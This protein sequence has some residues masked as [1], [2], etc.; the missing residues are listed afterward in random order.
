MQ[1]Y[2][3]AASVRHPGPIAASAAEVRANAARVAG[4][5]T[6]SV[7]V[8]RHATAASANAN[9]AEANLRDGRTGRF[10]EYMGG[11]APVW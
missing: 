4:A 7:P 2:G 8:S 6:A 9:A 1:A 3:S 11:R 5:R 10:A